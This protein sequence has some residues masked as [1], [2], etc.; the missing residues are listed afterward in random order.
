MGLDFEEIRDILLKKAEAR[1]PLQPFEMKQLAEQSSD[2]LNEI[3]IADIYTTLAQNNPEPPTPEQVVKEIMRQIK[4]FNVKVGESIAPTSTI[5][6]VWAKYELLDEE[7]LKQATNI[8]FEKGYIIDI[9]NDDGNIVT[10]L[11]QKG[12]DAL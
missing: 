12:F 2:G 10:I 9:K 6:P 4:H 11:T 3:Q 1:E 7:I 8:L 5:H